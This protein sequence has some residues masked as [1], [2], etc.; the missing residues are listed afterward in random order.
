MSAVIVSAVVIVT[1]FVWMYPATYLPRWLI[2]ALR[3]R[4]PSPPWQWPFVLAFTGVR[5]IVS[6]AAALAIPLRHRRRPAVSRSRSDPV[7]DLC[8][9]PGDAGGPGP[10]AAGGDPRARPRQCRATRASHR[11]DRGV[12]GAAAGG[13][14]GDR[15]AAAA[16]G[17]DGHRKLVELYDEVELTLISAER[18][19]VNDLYRDGKLKDEARRRIER[20]LDL[21]EA[22]LENLRSAE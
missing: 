4:D 19:A 12:R 2:P 3:R 20:E 5:G 14:G 22:G 15:A 10:A 13:R 7:S 11:C 17:E 8:R 21:R 18:T 6:L 9:D 1:R 16:G